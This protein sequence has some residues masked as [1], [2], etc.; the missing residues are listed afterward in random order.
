MRRLPGDAP[1]NEIVESMIRVDHAGEYGAMRIYAGQLAFLKDAKSRE[2]VEH[3]QAQEKRHLETF[4]GLMRERKVRPTVL[5]PLWHAAGYAL[6]AATALL[7]EKAAFACTVAVESVIDKHYAA[8]GEKLGTDEAALKARLNSSAP[9]RRNTTTRASRKEQNRRR[10]IRCYRQPSKGQ[11]V[12]PSGFPP[13]SRIVPCRINAI[14]C[15]E[16][17]I[18]FSI[19]TAI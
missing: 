11:A 17:T 14:F 7:G 19:V 16:Q 2:L 9:R 8:Q 15:I 12:L 5:M 13:A 4:E 10:F 3:M 18:Q 6:G 1:E